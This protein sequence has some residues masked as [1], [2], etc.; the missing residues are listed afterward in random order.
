MVQLASLFTAGSYVCLLYFLWLWVMLACVTLYTSHSVSGA[1]QLCRGSW[2]ASQQYFSNNCEPMASPHLQ[3][4]FFFFFSTGRSIPVEKCSLK[5]IKSS[6][7]RTVPPETASV[8]TT[9]VKMQSENVT[10]GHICLHWT[11]L[12]K[13]K[14]LQSR[15][16][17]RWKKCYPRRLQLLYFEEHYCTQVR[18]VKK[19]VMRED[20]RSHRCKL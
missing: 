15:S 16:I 20:V 2:H 5:V 4:H 13:L 12:Q 19:D 6:I 14:T 8:F 9:A 10:G 18:S 3:V 1:M 17:A 7:Y 11:H